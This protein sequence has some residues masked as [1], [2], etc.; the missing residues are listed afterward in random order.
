MRLGE[1][2]KEREKKRKKERELLD[3]HCGKHRCKKLVK[4][5]DPKMESRG[6]GMHMGTDAAAQDHDHECTR[7]LNRRGLR[8]TGKAKLLRLLG[9]LRKRRANGGSARRARI[10][11]GLAERGWAHGL[12][13]LDCD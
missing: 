13:S 12:D 11:S 9:T 3:C 5:G 2:E 10:G 7:E 6:R 4:P 1:G 8:A